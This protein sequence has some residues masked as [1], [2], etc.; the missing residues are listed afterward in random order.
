ML[1]ALV[2][3]LSLSACSSYSPSR[4]YPQP[5]YSIQAGAGYHQP[6]YAYYG[7]WQPGWFVAAPYY[8]GNYW[9]YGAMVY[10]PTYS[11]SYY[12]S[13]HY[14]GGGAYYGHY[15]PYSD[16]WYYPYSGHYR[17]VYGHYYGPYN[18]PYY[19]YGRHYGSGYRPSSGRPY[20]GNSHSYRPPGG[21]QAPRPDP[22]VDPPAQRE[23]YQPE[24]RSATVV[25]EQ[26]GIS[27]SVGVAPGQDGSQGMV[28]TNRNERKA[29]PS[30]L[31]PV[32]ADNGTQILAP[33][34]PV[35]PETRNSA[36][37]S[38]TVP[39]HVAPARSA[40]VVTPGRRGFNANSPSYRAPGR[41][42]SVPAGSQPDAPRTETGYQHQL[43]S[44]NAEP[45]AVSRAERGQP[46]DIGYG[47]EIDHDRDRQ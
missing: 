23:R 28:V 26:E 40:A 22:V 1:L 33:A 11:S 45:G 35:M 15:Y 27:R 41:G 39:V 2:T 34:A 10:W 13:N 4:N 29:R 46:A 5:Y 7:A 12:Y 3:L 6:N 20:Y 43:G 36:N 9:G 42:N 8:P 44:G 17:H 19:G 25:V 47:Q 31:H 24:R 32:A 21:Q 18:G 30:R 14:Y 16:P 38:N 37:P